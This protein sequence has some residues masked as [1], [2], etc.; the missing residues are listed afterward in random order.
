MIVAKKLNKWYG[1]LHVLRDLE[2]EVKTLK[3]ES[4]K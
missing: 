4:K 1:N 3:K 2:L